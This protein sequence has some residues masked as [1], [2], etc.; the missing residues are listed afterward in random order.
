MKKGF[1]FRTFIKALIIISL[2]T[3]ASLL[4]AYSH[5]EGTGGNNLLVRI[6]STFFYILRFPTHVILWKSVGQN[7][8]LYFGGLIVNCLFYAFLIERIVKLIRK[9]KSG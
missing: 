5:D 4:A 9:D 6:F 3:F 8:Q 7:T 2:L 1:S